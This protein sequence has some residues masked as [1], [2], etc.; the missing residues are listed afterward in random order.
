MS[1]DAAAPPSRFDRVVLSVGTLGDRTGPVPLLAFAMAGM[2]VVQLGRTIHDVDIFWQLKL[3]EITLAQGLPA[4][5]PFLA[6]Y[7]N[8]PLAVVAWLAQVAYAYT[9][10]L[11]GWTLLWLVDA[12]VWF[13]GFAVV[14]RHCARRM[15]NDWP[16]AIGLWI[17]WFAALSTASVRP[18]SFA[19]LAFGL[20]IVLLRSNLSTARTALIGGVLFI[21][22]QNLHPSAV[23]GALALGAAIVA[24]TVQCLRR[25]RDT[26]PWRLLALLPLAA[27]ATV[28]TPAGFDIYRISR[29]NAELSLHLGVAEWMPMTWKAGE[30]GRPFAW[31]MLLVIATGLLVRGARARAS[32]LA[33][34]FAFTAAMLYSHRFVLFWGIAVV[35]LLCELFGSEGEPARPR[36]RCRRPLAALVLALGI[37]LPTILN[38][39]P[40]ADYYP[41][42]GIRKLRA[43]GVRGTVYTTYYWGGMLA[44]A[45]HP[46]W[47]V[48]HDGRYYLKS[49]SEWDRYFD[50]THRALA[51]IDELVARY[52]PA[53][54]FLRPGIDDELIEKLEQDSRWRT[55][56][57]DAN[58]VVSVPATVR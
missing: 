39:A 19:A 25:K 18:Q 3:G 5:E 54:F 1:I 20:L 11:G 16:A 37:G 31:T 53:A 13:G 28:C 57:A 32:T 7:E 42:E 22:W 4:H 6:G 21:V 38:P 17:G 26:L 43:H 56:F 10:Q 55:L 30:F 24:E 27:V 41:F 29:L 2:L 58:C 14:A 15:P 40:F 49:I 44:E 46:D 33:I 52:R 9:R 35:P 23:V 47:R 50:E 34:A 12:L 51:T 48:T 8:E 36:S 45:G